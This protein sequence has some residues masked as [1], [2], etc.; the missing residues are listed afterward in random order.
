MRSLILA[1]LTHAAA[2][3]VIT[4]AGGSTTGTLSGSVNGVGSRALFNQ[5]FS[6]AVDSSGIVYVADFGNQK[7]RAIYPNR[8]VI[9]LAG[10]STTGTL[11]GSVNGV[12]SSA[13]FNQPLGIA[14]DSSGIVYV[15]DYNNHKIRAIYPNQTVITLAGGNATGTVQGSVDG[16]G[17]SALFFRARGVAVDSSGIVYVADKNNHKIRAIYPVTCLPGSYRPALTCLQCPSGTFSN[18]GSTSCDQC[19]GGHVCPAGTSSWAR[20]NCG[21]GNYCPD[22]SGIPIPC[23]YQ[24]PPSGGWGVLQVQGPAFLVET[25]HCLN[26][27]FWNFTSGGDGGVLSRC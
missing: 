24:V 12:G 2:Q 3:T 20:L 4:L 23:P 21:R 26:H 8:A 6:V 17:S 9:T 22:G 19:P 11:P 10:G 16:V 27:C 14:V 18:S 13:L 1:H 7:I 15:A 5:P 25:A